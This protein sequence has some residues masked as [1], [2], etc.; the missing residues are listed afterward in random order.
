MHVTSNTKILHVETL[1]VSKMQVLRQKCL[2]Q[3]A[4]FSQKNSQE[5]TTTRP[6]RP[7]HCFPT[8]ISH[9]MKL[10]QISEFAFLIHLTFQHGPI[11]IT[12]CIRCYMHALLTVHVRNIVPKICDIHGVTNPALQKL[13]V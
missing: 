7:Q 1:N 5:S 8:I 4:V 13:L 9:K 12:S 10:F 6:T 11:T 3:N 2:Y